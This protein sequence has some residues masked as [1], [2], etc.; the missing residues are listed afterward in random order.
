M[1]YC[2]RC[3]SKN[4]KSN[5]FCQ[6]CGMPLKKN[7]RQEDAETIKNQSI[8]YF[9]RERRRLFI[10]IAILIFIYALHFILLHI[11]D[12]HFY[13]LPRRRYNVSWGWE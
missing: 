12:G 7:A 9:I 13:L 2:D 3:G 11:T 10:I 5:S 1:K 4:Q 6:G 8:W